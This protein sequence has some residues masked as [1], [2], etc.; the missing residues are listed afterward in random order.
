MTLRHHQCLFVKLLEQ[1]ILVLLFVLLQFPVIT[2]NSSDI[3]FYDSNSKRILIPQ[4]QYIYEPIQSALYLLHHRYTDKKNPKSFC[5]A[6]VPSPVWFSLPLESEHLQI[7]ITWG[8]T[9]NPPL[10]DFLIENKY[11]KTDQQEEG[12]LQTYALLTGEL[13]KPS[14]FVITMIHLIYQYQQAILL[15]KPSEIYKFHDEKSE[16]KESDQIQALPTFVIVSISSLAISTVMGFFTNFFII[17]SHGMNSLKAGNINPKEPLLFT[18]GLFNIAFQ[19]TMVANDTLLFLWSDLYYSDFIYTIFSILLLFTIFSSFW[20]TF[21]LCGFYYIMLGT[22]EKRWFVHLKQNIARIVPWML[23][24]C[25]LLSSVISVPVAWSI[26]KVEYFDLS[27]GNITR[28]FTLEISPPHMNHQ[29]LLVASIFGCCIPLILVAIANV[30]IVKYLCNHVTYLRKS[31]GGISVQSVE[32]SVSAAHTVTSL[33]LLYMSFF[34]SET[35]LIMDVF[36]VDSPWI[37]LCL[38]T[39]YSYAPVQSVILINGSPNLRDRIKT[40]I[41]PCKFTGDMPSGD[42]TDTS[43]STTNLSLS[44]SLDRTV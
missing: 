41:C 6:S 9:P 17:M 26:K 43:H 34:V 14:L 27:A 10:H 18:L 28:N 25:M 32:A 3:S 21:C 44:L 37:S 7:S 2:D 38:I 15:K 29:Y 30:L 13:H 8:L 40:I 33:L 35:L 42:R 23:L 11:T 22:F 4:R 24:S 1:Q 39:V 12:F 19:C 36:K 20:F 16:S 5:T 31:S